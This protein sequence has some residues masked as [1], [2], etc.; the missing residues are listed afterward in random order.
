[1]NSVRND[2]IGKDDLDENCD[3][4]DCCDDASEDEKDDLSCFGGITTAHP[5]APSGARAGVSPTT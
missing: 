1:M 4:P 2:M 5:F 3:Y